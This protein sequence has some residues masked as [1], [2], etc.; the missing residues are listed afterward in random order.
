MTALA[1]EHR[2]MLEKKIVEAR[3]LSEA[4][5]RAALENLAVHHHEP[6]GHMD[7]EARRLRNH[8][9]A[10][11]RQLGDRQDRSGRL[12]INHLVTECAYE[13]WHRMLFARFL[14]ENDLLIEPKMQ[15][16]ITLDEAEELAKE[17]PSSDE[18]NRW[19]FA[20]RCAQTMLPQIFRPDDPLL[21]VRLARE[22]RVGLERLLAELPAEMFTAS[23]ALGWVYQYWQ[24]VRK[25]EVNASGEKIGADQLPAVTQLFTEEYMVSFLIHNTLG[26]WWAGKKLREDPSLETLAEDEDALRQVLAL[27]GVNW[28]YL[29]F[30]RPGE[31]SENDGKNEGEGQPDGQEESGPW[32]PASGTFEAWPK[33][34]AQLRV[35]DPC[36]GSG[37]FLVSLLRHL[38]PLRVAEDGLPIRE[39]VDAVLAE[40]LHGLELDERCAQIAVF[41]LALAA[42]TYPDAGG[43]RALPEIQV[44]CCGIAPQATEEEWKALAKGNSGLRRSLETL[45]KLFSAAPTLGSL[46]NP[47]E[48]IQIGTLGGAFDELHSVL[49]QA[50]AA[51]YVAADVETHELAVSVHSVTTAV[52][53]LGAEYHLVITNVPYLA[54]GKQDDVL[55][56]YIEKHHKKAKQDLATAFVERALAFNT[57]GGAAALVTPQN[58]LFLGSYKRLRKELLETVEWN[59]VARLGTRAF[60]TISGEI[61]NV[62]LL[63]LTRSQPADVHQFAGLDASGPRKPR[64]KAVVLGGENG[65]AIADASTSEAAGSV[66][67]VGQK[68]QLGNP[69]GIV[70][71]GEAVRGRLLREYCTA[72]SGCSAGDATRFIYQFWEIPIV[73]ECWEYY[74]TTVGK[75]TEY[76][77]RSEVV[78]WEREQGAMRLL[79]DSVKHL[80]HAAQNWLRGKP[81]WEK[82]GVVISQMRELPATLYTGE[83]YDCNCCAIVPNDPEHLLPLWAYCSSPEYSAQVRRVDQALKVTP[84]T[85]L[86]VPFDLTHWQEV[87]AREY[88]EGLPEPYSDDPT[89]WIFH[90][91]PE[92]ST[93]PLHVAVA[94]LLGYQWPAETDPNMRL[95]AEARQLAD[96]CRELDKYSDRD[97]IV[98]IAPVRREDPAVDRLR[99]L[100]GSAFRGEW[101][102]Q[103]EAALLKE[104]GS[105]TRDLEDWLRNDFF[106]QHCKLF[107]HRPF[108]WHIWDGRARDGFHALVS[109]H[110]LAEGEGKGRKLLENLTY[111]YLGDWIARQEDEVRRGEGGAEDRLAAATEL[112][113]RLEAILAGEPPFDLFVRWKSLSEQAIGW[114]P[115]INDGVRINIRPFMAGDLP[116]G[117]RGAGVLRWKPNINWRKDRGKEPHR[118]RE[119]YPWFWGWD[120]V[121]QDWAG[122]T[123]FDGKRHNDLHYGVMA[124]QGVQD[125]KREG[126][127]A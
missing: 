44:A 22:H 17:A 60:Q 30:V 74:Q 58:W 119:E 13:H 18:R 52:R 83:R 124:K 42:W 65:A 121:S 31:S 7:A 99:A 36:C 85:L 67:M 109:Y 11:A 37:H 46:I 28:E 72:L 107:H 56:E 47:R 68:G 50:A 66:T 103:R 108:I 120:G 19:S 40:N 55:R 82:S 90:G 127:G 41:A 77:G 69:D 117:R 8:L 104:T 9:R 78:F 118:E 112:K 125:R 111:S 16:A 87:A 38:V 105:K 33:S 110:R 126:T 48:A 73:S 91:R 26:A 49:E 116:G 113:K 75:T 84:H 57:R 32:V 21:R 94:R 10:R 100:L 35:L 27:P 71:I 93:S 79:A 102:P 115:D 24:S 29:R 122:G 76:G 123:T 64:E 98:C 106:E 6:Y 80:N 12:G 96:S 5:A 61:V 70:T 1:D 43:F 88:P 92:A 62:T 89:Q 14:A 86:K 34:A 25:K 3:E 101:T 51:D 81:N 20:S 15:I 39:A 97:G 95:S 63:C 54:R 114:E 45:H 4:G 23:D 2:R 53:L 59:V